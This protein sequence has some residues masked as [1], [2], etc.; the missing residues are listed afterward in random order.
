M[1]REK[2]L[3]DKLINGIDEVI[4]NDYIKYN[5]QKKIQERLSQCS[6]ICCFGIGKFLKDCVNITSFEN[7]NLL[8][9]NDKSKWGKIF[10]EENVYRLMN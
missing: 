2:V 1:N 3:L 10:L 4:K 8:C 5:K 7:F 6:N 9:D